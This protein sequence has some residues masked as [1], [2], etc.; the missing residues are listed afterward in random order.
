MT[1]TEE[2]WKK[3]RDAW[4]GE[5]GGELYDRP[6]VFWDDLNKDVQDVRSRLQYQKETLKI[7][8]VDRLVNAL[9]EGRKTWAKAAARVKKLRRTRMRSSS[10]S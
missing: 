1:A 7:R 3:A 6:S 5:E 2:D 4:E 10:E 9:I 8:T